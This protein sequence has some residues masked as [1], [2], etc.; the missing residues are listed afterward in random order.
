MN[1]VDDD[2]DGVKVAVA[3]N[4]EGH[5]F[6]RR[7][8]LDQHAVQTRITTLRTILRGVHARVA[9]LAQAPEN[10]GVHEGGPW[11]PVMGAL[12]EEIDRLER[13]ALDRYGYV[14]EGV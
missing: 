6:R 11:M 13:L 9:E 4:R 2:F 10:E 12:Q 3:I 5:T 7:A 8:D 14:V 1:R